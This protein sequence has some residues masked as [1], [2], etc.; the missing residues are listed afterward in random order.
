MALRP[1]AVAREDMVG[2]W[3]CYCGALGCRFGGDGL[4]D[5][6]FWSMF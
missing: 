4:S 1:R 5:S 2:W 6:G 3:V